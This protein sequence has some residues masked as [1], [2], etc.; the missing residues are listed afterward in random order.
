MSNPP[1]QITIN[2]DQ[3]LPLLK[4]VRRLLISLLKQVEDLIKLVEPA[5]G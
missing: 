2:A 1:Q 5:G 4:S 3:L